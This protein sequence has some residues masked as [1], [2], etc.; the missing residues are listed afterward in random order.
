M[1]P[2]LIAFSV[3]NVLLGYA[4]IRRAE[5]LM[6]RE[7]RLAWAS[8]RL[9]AIAAF[10]AWSLPLI[11]IVATGGAWSVAAEDWHWAPLA[12]LAPVGWLLVMGA[13]FAVVDFAEDGVLDLA[14][15]TLRKRRDPR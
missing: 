6:S 9:H 13:F 4:S 1:T 15:G 3:F 2:F 5:R 8:P 10:A 12:I 11:C 14:R 7:E